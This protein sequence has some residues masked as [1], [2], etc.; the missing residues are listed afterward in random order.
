MVE[1]IERWLSVARSGGGFWRRHLTTARCWTCSSGWR[2]KPGCAIMDIYNGECA[3]SHKADESPVTAAD[4]AAEKIILRGLRE[5]YPEIPCVAE[6]EGGW[7]ALA[8]RA[9]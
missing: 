3:V 1:T 4:H 2:S 8:A 9:R 5:A 6:E 7:R